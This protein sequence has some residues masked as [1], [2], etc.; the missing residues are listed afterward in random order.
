MVPAETVDDS[1]QRSPRQMFLHGAT[2]VTTIVH[3]V[4]RVVHATFAETPTPSRISGR[5]TSKSTKAYD[6]DRRSL[7]IVGESGNSAENVLSGNIG[8]FYTTFTD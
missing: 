5:E 3:E 7:F 6:I 4:A 2:L 8:E 1:R